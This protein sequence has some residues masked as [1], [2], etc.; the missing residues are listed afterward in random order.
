MDAEQ[1]DSCSTD[2]FPN[3]GMQRLA[4][5]AR[6]DQCVAR[7]ASSVDPDAIL[8]WMFPVVP[9]MQPTLVPA[10]F[11]RLGWVYER[12]EDGWRMLAY[13][14]GARVRL[15]SRHGV[16]HTERFA[17]IAAAVA[18]LPPRRLMLDGE[19][20]V[21]DD[22]LVSQ[23]HLLRDHARNAAAPPATLVAFDIRHCES[24]DL[25]T[26][27]LFYRRS[28]LEDAIAGS[29]LIVPALR[30]ED[31]GFA[32]WETVKRNGWEGLVAK[33]STSCYVGGRT[34]AWLKVKVRDERDFVVLGVE[35]PPRGACALF[36]ASRGD[37]GLEYVGRAQWGVTRALVA[38]ILE[39]ATAQAE[40]ACPVGDAN[41][42]LWLAPRIVVEVSFSRLMEGRLRDPV[43]RGL[44]SAEQLE[45][46]VS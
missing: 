46:R 27:P 9:P 43:V 17:D 20:C 37:E 23:F 3:G 14:D 6:A 38:R 1:C 28:M 18:A 11:H 34:H 32:A 30:L 19:V 16:D 15:V 41:D 12:K 10:P 44:R 29:P 2:A 31:D 42:V 22:K 25:R 21:F 36:L 33:D 13:K 8:K 39:S 24:E 26:R 45:R 40:P 5:A 7:S 35:A 4:D